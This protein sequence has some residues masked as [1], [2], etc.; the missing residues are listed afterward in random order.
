M[1]SALLYSENYIS[2]SFYPPGEQHNSY[3]IALS[4][5]SGLALSPGNGCTPVRTGRWNILSKRS[6]PLTGGLAI[7]E[8][9][10]SLSPPVIHPGL[11]G[12][13]ETPISDFQLWLNIRISWG[14]FKKYLCSGLTHQLELSLQVWPG[15]RIWAL[16][17]RLRWTT[18][19]ENR[20]PTTLIFKS[21]LVS[22]I[23]TGED[24]SPAGES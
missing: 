1:H 19:F 21:M 8:D 7:Q 13:I 15:L 11:V 2:E 20:W 5:V 10:I 23:I 16:H 12:C 22:I 17:R 18:K 3:S 24:R 6:L 4:N 9:C 14:N